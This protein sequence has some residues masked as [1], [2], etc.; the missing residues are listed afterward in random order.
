MVNSDTHSAPV[1]L[2]GVTRTFG[3]HVALHPMTLDIQAGEFVS[4]LGPSGCGKT[5]TLRI[6][7]G[8]ESTDAGSVWIGNRDVTHVSPNRRGLGMVF[9]N[10]ALFPHM[11]VAENIAF[12]LEMSR[13]PKAEIETQVARII[14]MVHLSQFAD[15][16]PAKLSG[17]QQQRVALARSLVTNPA[18]LLLDEPMAALD[19]NLRETMQYEL[20]QIQETL[21]TTTIMVTHDQ[22]EALSLSD[23]IVV[24]DKGHLLQA[25][26]PQEIYDAP[27]NRFVSEFLGASNL[28][29][30]EVTGLDGDEAVLSPRGMSGVTLRAAMR[31]GI[32]AGEAV[33]LSVRPERISMSQAQPDS[34]HQAVTGTIVTHVFRGASHAYQIRMN[35]VETP[36]L[37]YEQATGHPETGKRN[38]GS[39]VWAHWA[40]EGQTVL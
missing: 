9:Q 4:L 21:G 11:S 10:Y 35:G 34:S 40:S 33:T 29:E 12:G 13:M 39:K 36:I 27:A 8:L 30:C 7:A 28:I 16:M 26:A 18:V 1:S 25:G 37:V 5:T 3:D 6:V 20:R 22:E 38:I 32:A 19:K 14:D 2:R 23:R 31:P 17:G 24:M 15:R